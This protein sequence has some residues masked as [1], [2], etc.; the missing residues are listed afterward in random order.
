MPDKDD[1]ALLAAISDLARHAGGAIMAVYAKAFAVTKKQDSSPVTEADHAAEAIIVKGLRALTPAVPVVAEE[2]MAAGTTP[3]FTGD[4]YWL[5]DPLDGTK[6]FVKKNG[7]FTVNIALIRARRPVLGVVFAPAPDLLWRGRLGHGAQ[8]I[9]QGGAPTAIAARLPLGRGLTVFASR[10][11]ATWKD[12]E[13]E[14]FLSQH[15]IAE[16]LQTGSSMKFCRLAEGAGDLYPRF[17]PTM[18]WDTA[19]G[20]AVLEAAGGAVE[21]PEGK[22][23]LYGK[24]GFKNGHFI[25]WGRRA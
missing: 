10:S 16:R 15:T 2:E 11:H 5:V 14:D 1:A 17:G 24:P 8:R 4:A 21:T 18:E 9:A 7:E 20:Q 19:A 3:N 22:A 12:H 23:F 13:L 25:A 6:E